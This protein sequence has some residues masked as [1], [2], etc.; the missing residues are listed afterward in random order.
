M[1]FKTR[2]IFIC[3]VIAAILVSLVL[4]A[5]PWPRKRQRWAIAG[6][7]TF[8]GW[9]AWNLLLNETEA[10]GFDVDAPVVMASWQ[11]AGSGVLA[12]VVVALALTVYEPKELASR[13][14]GTAAVAGL[15]AFVF[16]I[17]VL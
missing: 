8:L 12:F 13:V 11:D 4:F 2:D 16:D 6:A 7:A 9:I 17:F 3:G 15:V 14:V 5:L 10:H 1:L